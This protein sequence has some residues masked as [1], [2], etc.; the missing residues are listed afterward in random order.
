MCVFF[1]PGSSE[2]LKLKKGG[3]KNATDYI[4]SVTRNRSQLYAGGSGSRVQRVPA[5]P[6]DSEFMQ[7]GE[8]R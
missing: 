1:Y 5:C 8:F 2:N 7:K 6:V 4:G 3:D